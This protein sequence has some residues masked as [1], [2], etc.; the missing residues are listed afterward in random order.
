V[1]VIFRSVVLAGA[2]SILVCSCGEQKNESQTIQA[3]SKNRSEEE[4]KPTAV[5]NCIE[6]GTPAPEVFSG[7]SISLAS[8]HTSSINILDAIDFD[9]LLPN[10]QTIEARKVSGVIKGYGIYCCTLLL[11]VA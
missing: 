8:D 2:V 5:I 11:I 1:C 10:G 6:L 4:S 7:Y 3:T 9:I